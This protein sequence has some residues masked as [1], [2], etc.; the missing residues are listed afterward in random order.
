M[1]NQDI[2]VG[3]ISVEKAIALI[4]EDTRKDAKVDTAFLLRNL[5][6]LRVDGNY[7]IKKMRHENGRVV[8]DGEEFVHIF[9]EFE[10]AS[11]EHAITE[12]YKEV[13]GRS[14]DPE[15]IGIRKMTTTVDDEKNPQGRISVNTSSSTKVG[16][17]IQ[18]GV[19]QNVEEGG[20]R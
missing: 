5:P 1:N 18:S 19:T 20:L 11:L 12:H 4:N 10:R 15:T 3:F 14:I 13:T 6:Y 9:N 8:P 7:T 17:D 2:P 16:D